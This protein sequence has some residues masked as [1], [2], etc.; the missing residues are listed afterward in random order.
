[1]AEPKRKERTRRTW[2]ERSMSKERSIPKREASSFSFCGWRP[3]GGGRQSFDSGT[4]EIDAVFW[5]EHLQ[6]E[7]NVSIF[8]VQVI[9]KTSIL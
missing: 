4:R 2:M 8:M 1:M 6:Q 5:S 9:E 7:R 3:H